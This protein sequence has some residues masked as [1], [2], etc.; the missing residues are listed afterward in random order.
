MHGGKLGE[1]LVELG[2]LTRVEL[3]GAISEQWDDLRRSRRRRTH[4][5]S[6]SASPAA[7]PTE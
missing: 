6:V 2:F 1:T 5:A 3:A 7:S 4:A